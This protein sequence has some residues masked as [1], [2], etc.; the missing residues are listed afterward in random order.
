MQEFISVT[1]AAYK[2]LVSTETKDKFVNKSMVQLHL[3]D[4][5]LVS[6]LKSYKMNVEDKEFR[7]L[8]PVFNKD[9]E[10]YENQVTGAFVLLEI[11]DGVAIW[12]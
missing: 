9:K 7:I 2:Q 5:Q 10:G 1:E 11:K 6:K 12:N 4:E 8:K 3:S